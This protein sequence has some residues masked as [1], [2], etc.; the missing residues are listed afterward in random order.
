MDKAFIP[1]RFTFQGRSLPSPQA[2]HVQY[3]ATLPWYFSFNDGRRER[4]MRRVESE[5]QQCSK[6]G[7][8]LVVR[9]VTRSLLLHAAA[10]GPA[11]PRLV[12]RFP[13]QTTSHAHAS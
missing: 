12:V 5:A 13:P 9:Q 2:A 10:A 11:A 8:T 6:V 4:K 7:H 1:W 3:K